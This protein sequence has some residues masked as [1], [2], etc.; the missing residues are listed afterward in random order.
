[1]L[2]NFRIGTAYLVSMKTEEVDHHDSSAYA[3]EIP[4]VAVVSNVPFQACTFSKTKMFG[5]LRLHYET[6][7]VKLHS[8]E[9]YSLI[10]AQ[11]CR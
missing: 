7:S 5:I 4:P 10:S 9:G 8:R 11:G 2:V 6:S 1:M 3:H